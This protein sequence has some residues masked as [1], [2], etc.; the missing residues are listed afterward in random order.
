MVTWFVT[1]LGLYSKGDQPWNL[2]GRTDADPVFW[3]TDVK[4]WLIV[5]G[6]GKDWGQKERRA[7]EDEMAGWHHWCNE[8]EPGQ[9]P[10]DGEGQRGLVCCS[11]RGHKQSVMTGRLNNN[12]SLKLAGLF[13]LPI[14][15]HLKLFVC[16]NETQNF[17]LKYTITEWIFFFSSKIATAIYLVPDTVSELC[18]S[19]SGNGVCLSS[20]WS[21][22]SLFGCFDEQNAGGLTPLVKEEVIKGN[23][24]STWLHAH[25][26]NPATML[27][28]SLSHVGGP[29]CVFLLIIP[30]KVSPA[31]YHQ[32]ED[33]RVIKDAAFVQ[34]RSGVDASIQ[35]K[36]S[37]NS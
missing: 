30:A 13:F 26:G 32:F 4:R 29:L 10:G 28:G 6:A 23:V 2:T 18:H 9:T 27:W 24:A 19:P 17:L 3:S 36:T 16:F 31:C 15:L 7:S 34:G 8:H 12:I 37:T 21:R 20:P 1:Y 25:P 33:A 14:S 5:P 11:P 22:M 35:D